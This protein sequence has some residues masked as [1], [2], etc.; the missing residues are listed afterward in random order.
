MVIQRKAFLQNQVSTKNCFFR[1][2]TCVK[3]PHID[4]TKSYI[5]TSMHWWIYLPCL[6]SDSCCKFTII[7]Q[8]FKRW[9]HKTYHI[10]YSTD[11]LPRNSIEPKVK[12]SSL[13]ASQSMTFKIINLRNDFGNIKLKKKIFV[14]RW[15][16]KT[17]TSLRDSAF[18]EQTYE[19]QDEKLNN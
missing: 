15:G 13:T 12:I 14:H 8:Y 7:L 3:Y 6:S 5:L 1:M 11:Y 16:P 2:T 10:Y 19:K 9:M 4:T 18:G 17:Y